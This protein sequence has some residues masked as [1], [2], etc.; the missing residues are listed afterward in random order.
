MG[1]A[2]PWDSLT[3]VQRQFQP[4]KM[5]IHAAMVHRMDL[6]IGRVVAK[7]KADGTYDDTLILF[8]SD[9]GASAEQII[10]GDGHDRDASPGS[11][12]SFLGLG[13]GLAAAAN[14]PFRGYKSWIHEGGISTPLIAHWPQGITA[15][16]E[17]RHHPGHLIDLAPTVVELAGGQWPTTLGGQPVPPTP[18]RSLVPAF[19]KDGSV[20]H[21]F[22]WWL[23]DDHRAIRLGDWKLVADHPK[24][25]ELYDLSQDRGE[26]RNQA[27]ENP[28][29]VKELEQ[30]WTRRFKEIRE[31]AT[32]DR[33]PSEPDQTK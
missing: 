4:V 13:P 6:E 26:N 25:W 32:Q 10:R 2:L 1:R 22:L 7:L 20:T 30:A 11:A 29:K 33:S 23:H 31:A 27:A 24:P 12:G 17:L 18:G 3:D 5:A 21:D 14:A 8:V 16:G 15:R 28:T 19:A 9:N